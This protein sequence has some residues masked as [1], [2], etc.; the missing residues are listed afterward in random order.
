MKTTV[1][2]TAISKALDFCSKYF[3]SNLNEISLYNPEIV[4]IARYKC[5]L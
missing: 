1:V 2:T 3:H 4:M 5:R